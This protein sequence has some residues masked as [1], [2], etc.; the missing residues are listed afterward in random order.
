MTIKTLR[1][2]PLEMPFK[3]NRDYLHGTSMYEEIVAYM[4][5]EKQEL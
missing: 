2:V 5:R 1:S 4:G 3:G